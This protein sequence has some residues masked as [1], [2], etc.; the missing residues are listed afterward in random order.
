[1][2][3]AV[4]VYGVSS[5]SIRLVGMPAHFHIPLACIE[6]KCLLIRSAEDQPSS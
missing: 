1:M 6:D 4:Q 2:P 3:R 5:Q